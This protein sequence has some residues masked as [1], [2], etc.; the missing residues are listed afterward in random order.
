[1]NEIWNDNLKEILQ[2]GSLKEYIYSAYT[3][4]RLNEELED[5]DIFVTG[6]PD[7]DTIYRNHGRE[8]FDCASLQNAFYDNED[9]IGWDREFYSSLRGLHLDEAI[10]NIMKKAQLN[11]SEI[12]EAHPDKKLCELIDLSPCGIDSKAAK[13]LGQ[14]KSLHECVEKNFTGRETIGALGEDSVSVF[15]DPVDYFKF[16][17]VELKKISGKKDLTAENVSYEL[18][19]NC[20]TELLQ[21]SYDEKKKEIFTAPEK[22]L[23]ELRQEK[24]KNKER[25]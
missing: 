16:F 5:G 18:V 23:F 24:N 4:T 9:T 2:A 6:I 12:M 7:S 21:K 22:A 17:S 15:G 1:M 14:Y 3:P 25:N 11:Y 8:I 19:V 13:N 20:V 10:R